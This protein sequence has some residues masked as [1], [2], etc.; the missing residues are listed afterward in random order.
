MKTYRALKPFSHDNLYCARD[1]EVELSDKQAEFLLTA[2][3]VE[4]VQPVEQK[5]AK[6]AKAKAKEA[7]E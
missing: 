2:G 6:P 7:G 5:A 3:F 4:P 1:A